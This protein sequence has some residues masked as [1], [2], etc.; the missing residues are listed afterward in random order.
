[1]S[2]R[3]GD[4]GYLT[5][6]QVAAMYDCDPTT[7]TRWIQNGTLPAFRLAGRAYRIRPEDAAALLAPVEPAAPVPTKHQGERDV[8]RAVRELKARGLDVR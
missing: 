8:E 6:K 5:V 4:D 3:N 7:V 1:M 2:K